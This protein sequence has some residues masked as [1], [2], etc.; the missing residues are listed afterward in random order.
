MLGFKVVDWCEIDYKLILHTVLK[1]FGQIFHIL[2]ERRGLG[3]ARNIPGT[4]AACRRHR[5]RLKRR[6][7]ARRP[8]SPEVKIFS[9]IYLLFFVAATYVCSE[10]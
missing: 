6:R 4:G 9:N 7:R 1:I 10:A 2:I 5:R 3:H 8:P